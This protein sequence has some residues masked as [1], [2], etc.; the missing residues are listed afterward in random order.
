MQFAKDTRIPQINQSET[1]RVISRALPWIKAITG[2][3]VVIK[4]GGSA[5]VNPELRKQVM[6]DIVLLKIMGV[7]PVI[8]HGGGSD[9]NA[10]M[11]RFGLPVEFRNGLRVTTEEGMD[12]VKMVLV[13]KVN[14][15]LVRDMN[16]HGNL[17]VGVSGSDAG[18]VVAEQTDPAL[19][20]VGTVTRINADY[21]NALVEDGYIPVIASVALGDDGGYFN[22][23]ADLVAGAIAGAI[24]AQ[25]IIF[26]TDVDGV[27]LD[28][29]DKDSLISN[30]TLEEA[31]GLV[32]G[33]QM[34]SGMIPKINACT[35]ALDAGVF[36]AHIVNGTI[37]HSILLEL[38]TDEGA[39][40]MVR[41]TSKDEMF[42]TH[43][44]GVVAS[45]LVENLDE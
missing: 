14:Q 10:A 39:G 26:L 11:E 9:I 18:T 35:N 25:K 43:P 8:V 15:E 45:K 38:L 16:S 6:S 32:D 20:R 40:T 29:D 44:L 4:Y 34:A 19:G 24:G 37:P 17:A 22:V 23:N 27:Y 42:D 2:K 5:M 21:I 41:R 31:R 3:T 36:R 12:V 30:M 33:G 1:A 7:N 13:G 28:F